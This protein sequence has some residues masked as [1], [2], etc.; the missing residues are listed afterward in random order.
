LIAL[1]LCSLWAIFLL[2]LYLATPHLLSKYKN[3]NV[4]VGWLV[5]LTAAL[6]VRLIPNF[7]LATG[8]GYDIESYKIVGDL[9]LQG[10]DI[11]SSQE[12]VNRHPYLPLQ[13]YWMALSSHLSEQFHI[14]FERI[15]RLVPILADVTIALVLYFFTLKTTTQYLALT[16][17]LLYAVNP[18]TTYVSA[19]HGQFDALP[20]LFTLLALYGFRRNAEISGAWVGLG[21]LTKSWPVL[22]VPPLLSK[23]KSWKKRVIFIVILLGV[24]SV[25][26]GLYIFLTKADVTPLFSRVLGYNRGIGV[27]GYTYLVRLLSF[28]KPDLSNMYSWLIQYGRWITLLGLG[29]VWWWTSLRRNLP[30]EIFLAILVSFFCVTHAFAIQYLSWIVPFAIVCQEY[31]WLKRFVLA[32]FAYMFLAYTTFILGMYIE[33]LIPLPQAD[34]LIIIPA[35][36]PAWLVCIGWTKNLLSNRWEVDNAVGD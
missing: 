33:N 2:V 9:V 31:S 3:L 28:V 14:P 18:I 20:S 25:G 5:V 6:V 12:T 21:I 24:L 36:L 23:I 29:L 15:V 17:G 4:K 16:A 13:M 7:V 30:Q 34:W 22:A 26:I 8:A 19:Y 35:G 32:A 1:L 27:W 10:E 11:Y